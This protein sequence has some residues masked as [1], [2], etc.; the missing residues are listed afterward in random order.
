MTSLE[1]VKQPI[2]VSTDTAIA[3]PLLAADPNNVAGVS[4][5][6]AVK[7]VEIPFIKV[8][9]GRERLSIFSRFGAALKKIFNAFWSSQ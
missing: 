8:I 7:G 3:S 2:P 5:I 4:I 6:I 9:V 1:Q